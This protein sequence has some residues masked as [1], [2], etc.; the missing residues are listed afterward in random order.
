LNAILTILLT[1]IYILFELDLIYTM[2]SFFRAFLGLPEFQEILLEEDLNTP[3]SMYTL[4]SI[5]LSPVTRERIQPYLYRM[6]ISWIFG[7]KLDLLL[8]AAIQIDGEILNI[9]AGLSGL[10]VTIPLSPGPGLSMETV[11]YISCHVAYTGNIK[12]HAYFPFFPLKFE[13]W[14]V[15]FLSFLSLKLPSEF[16]PSMRGPNMK[17]LVAFFEYGKPETVDEAVYLERYKYYFSCVWRSVENLESVDFVVKFCFRFIENLTIP[18]DAEFEYFT[19]NNPA[20]ME[21]WIRL[22]ERF[23]AE[24][25]QFVANRILSVSMIS[26][27]LPTDSRRQAE[28]LL[29]KNIFEA[30][31]ERPIKEGTAMN[32]NLYFEESVVQKVF[33]LLS[34]DGVAEFLDSLIYLCKVRKY[35][36]NVS[37]YISYD[38]L[39]CGMPDKLAILV[40]T[41]CFHHSIGY[42][43]SIENITNFGFPDDG[44]A[45]DRR[46]ILDYLFARDFLGYT[47]LHLNVMVPKFRL[48]SRYFEEKISMKLASLPIFERRSQCEIACS[49]SLRWF[50]PDILQKVLDHIEKYRHGEFLFCSLYDSGKRLSIENKEQIIR[51]FWRYNRPLN[52]NSLI[53]EC[54]RGM[55]IAIGLTIYDISEVHS[56]FR[57]V[58][59]NEKL[60]NLN[61]GHSESTTPGYVSCRKWYNS[62]RGSDDETEILS[63]SEA[64][65][66]GDSLANLI[67]DSTDKSKFRRYLILLWDLLTKHN[68]VHLISRLEL[69]VSDPLNRFIISRGLKYSPY[70]L[71]EIFLNTWYGHHAVDLTD[72]FKKI[73]HLS[74]I[75]IAAHTFFIDMS[76]NDIEMCFILVQIAYV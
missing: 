56:L 2:F 74:Q 27:T 42:S 76:I 3:D 17:N 64:L 55:G 67:Q 54:G 21:I 33:R 35:S 71:K 44:C 5:L 63:L 52:S 48:E 66:A 50:K 7:Y 1:R 4:C 29:I 46:I 57:Q 68:K 72:A 15:I 10:G 8:D 45:R 18:W 62:I 49:L 30:I 43:K 36:E 65:L 14:S 9:F 39:N 60:F 75:Q 12:F 58:N 38:I 73:D 23:Y 32:P 28:S 6:L 47:K 59:D 26:N 16:F 61:C 19:W 13:N 70:P 24:S 34:R 37:K 41:S 25:S 53:Y 31:K 51:I 40:Q 22:C 11:E 20:Q 69:K